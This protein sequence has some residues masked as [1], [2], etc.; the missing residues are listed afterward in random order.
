MG[1]FWQPDEFFRTVPGVLSTEVGYTG[2]R[3]ERPTY[4]QVCG[5]ATG[6]AE[7]VKI[8]F[9]PARVSYGQLLDLFWNNHDPTTLNRQ[10][11]D[12]GDQY[13]SAIFCEDEGQLAEAKASRDRVAREK[14]WGSDP[15]VTA[16]GPAPAWWPAEGYHQKYLMKRG[17]T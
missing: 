13:R 2:G 3:S 15:I 14:L 11:P 6:H 17:V 12:R 1:C 16:I 5:H 7:A 8:T 9:D 4:E 10:G